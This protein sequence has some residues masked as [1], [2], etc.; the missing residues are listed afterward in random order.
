MKKTKQQNKRQ[1]NTLLNY[2]TTPPQ[3][4]SM[5]PIDRPII[6]VSN[7]D[8][9]FTE[10]EE[11]AFKKHKNFTNEPEVLLDNSEVLHNNSEE[12]FNNYGVLT[13]NSDLL[14]NNSELLL[15]ASEILSSSSDLSSGIDEHKRTIEFLGQNENISIAQSMPAVLYKDDINLTKL[16]T[17]TQE[18][19]KTTE[20]LLRSP[21]FT[22]KSNTKS[23]VRNKNTANKENIHKNF[24]DK[25]N[26]VLDH[27]TDL[28]TT[29]NIFSTNSLCVLETQP[30]ESSFEMGSV[31]NEYELI[32]NSLASIT[33]RTENTGKTIASKP[34]NDK[35]FFLNPSFD[36]QKVPHS[37]PASD[38]TTLFIPTNTF[39]N[40]T[41][42]EKQYWKIKKDYFDVVIFF[43][44]GKFYEMF[45]NDAFIANKEF[46]LRLA[47]VKENEETNFKLRGG[48]PMAGI[49]ESQF[50]IYA[51]RFLNKGYKVARVDQKESLLSQ[52]MRNK[53]EGKKT[54]N[55]II[56][57]DISEILTVGTLNNYN[58]T[59]KHEISNLGAISTLEIQKD[60]ILVALL[61]YNSFLNEIRYKTFK[62]DK[63]YYKLRTH[64]IKHSV[65][66]IISEFPFPPFPF[67]QPKRLQRNLLIDEN[68]K[69][70]E[71]SVNEF[72]NKNIESKKDFNN[73][74]DTQEFLHLTK[75][76]KYLMNYLDYLRKKYNK[77]TIIPL[78]TN[79]HREFMSLNAISI[80]N[81]GLR[82]EFLKKFNNCKT[83]AGKRLFDF[84]TLNPLYDLTEIQ[85]RHL[86]VKQLSNQSISYAELKTLPDLEKLVGKLNGVYKVNDLFKLIMGIEMCLDFIKDPVFKV[87]NINSK[88]PFYACDCTV[89]SQ[90]RAH[91]T[92]SF[93]ALIQFNKEF[94]KKY[95]LTEDS[96]EAINGNKLKSEIMNKITNLKG[97][98][99]SYLK[100]EQMKLG[101]QLKYTS[102]GK[103]HF[104]F[105]IEK[106]DVAKLKKNKFFSTYQLCASTNKIEK[107][108]TDELKKRTNE[109]REFLE[110]IDQIENSILFEAVNYLNN[111]SIINCIIDLNYKIG[112]FDCFLNI[113]EFYVKNKHYVAFPEFI[114]RVCN[115][116]GPFI[117]AV[118]LINPIYEEYISNSFTLDKTLM[119][120]TGP[121]MAGKSTLL[122]T[123][124]LNT[125]L[126]QIG[127]P[128]LS[129]KYKTILFDKLFIRI[130][131]SDNLLKGESSFKIEMLETANFLNKS[132]K[133]SLILV[134]ELGRGTSTKD[135]QSICKSIIDFLLYKKAIVFFST[136]YFQM[137]KD[138]EAK[139]N[140]DVSKAQIE[141]CHMKYLI[142]NENII[143]LFK[144]VKG[145]CMDS[146]GIYLARRAGFPEDLITAIDTFKKEIC[147]K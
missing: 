11:A 78:N 79:T 38:K 122:R 120:L 23:K 55:Q 17:I 41:P 9:F 72:L 97:A 132:T 93:E 39:K 118:D 7:S 20:D 89:Y 105:Q 65:K 110:Q 77:I 46:G 3:K 113:T 60:T 5:D 82:T 52:Q 67:I 30:F 25:K 31:A 124:G 128:I 138:M 71:L 137:V 56:E 59:E 96:I 99:K 142:E 48:M 43:K 68:Y 90:L 115:E 100:E 29:P 145:V 14:L 44:K 92:S 54:K 22:E 112:E 62:D 133:N 24:H 139:Y 83:S 34:E 130:G 107:F 12:T 114:C 28:S 6:S 4:K 144:L 135:G 75:A 19:R 102:H 126:A 40:F 123:I 61:I 101:V 85:R 8:V 131:S 45:S 95:K 13:N 147:N 74:N 66:E 64:I 91:K 63:S 116:N 37:S 2:F 88:P 125:I 18:N 119:I 42:F 121:N 117:E 49:P 94:R 69:T 80:E 104:L 111:Q 76:Y 10:S 86:I 27:T 106:N 136:H 36:A 53:E 81:L 50:D 146:H 109:Y 129:K 70:F 58:L 143:F 33:E 16:E 47:G 32:Q 141:I 84:W 127:F 26:V 103:D 21:F 51:S 87:L 73:K 98:L 35:F 134:D 140:R 1:K 15:N 57:R 108:Q